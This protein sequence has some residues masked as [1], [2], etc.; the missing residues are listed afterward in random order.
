RSEEYSICN[1]CSKTFSTKGNLKSHLKIH[2]GEKPFSCDRCD[3][4][5]TEKSSLKIHNR[6]HN[7][8]KPYK[9]KI[10]GRSFSQ[11]GETWGDTIGYTPVNIHIGV[12]NVTSRSRE[13]NL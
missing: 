7:G 13:D 6:I 8:E 9:C 10:C 5:F 1:V 11:A 4:R 12:Q 3:S 2:T